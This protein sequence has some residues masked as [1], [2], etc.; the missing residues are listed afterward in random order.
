[1]ATQ[2]TRFHPDTCGCVVDYEW[3]DTLPPERIVLTPFQLA[4]CELHAPILQSSGL[5]AAFDAVLAHNRESAAARAAAN[6]ADGNAK[7]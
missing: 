7:E 3:D 2:R 4:P 5:P 1:M 6:E